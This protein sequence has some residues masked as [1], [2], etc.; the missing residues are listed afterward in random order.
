MGLDWN[1]GP[2]AKM[3][4]EKEWERLFGK[5]HAKWCWNR[6]GKITRFQEIS[7]DA[8]TTLNAPTVGQEPGATRWALDMYAKL[9]EKTESEEEFLRRMKGFRVLDLVKP[10]D[11]LPRYTYGSPGGYVE[12]YSFR[13]QFLQDA[14]SFLGEELFHEAY[15]SKLP[16]ETIVY[17]K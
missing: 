12:A 7:Q 8:F 14:V 3:G 13:A 9:P 11:G 15:A 16:R 5:L 6:A 2:K 1:P 10:C 4:H 17:G